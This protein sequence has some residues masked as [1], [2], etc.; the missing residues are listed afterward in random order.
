[1]V[2]TDLPAPTQQCQWPPGAGKKLLEQ[3]RGLRV[4]GPCEN[5]V[6]HYIMQRFGSVR[7]N[8][9]SRAKAA[10]QP[11]PVATAASGGKAGV[12]AGMAGTSPHRLHIV[13]TVVIAQRR[14]QKMSEHTASRPLRPAPQ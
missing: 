14:S 7:G 2:F 5:P 3:P 6:Y 4:W 13:Q 12:T 1:M 10:L 11:R 9:S 8:L